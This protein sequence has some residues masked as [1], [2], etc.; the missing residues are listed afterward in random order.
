MNSYLV[1][2]E[3]NKRYGE[4]EPLFDKIK[5]F[6]TQ[7]YQYTGNTW[8]IKSNLSPNDIMTILRPHTYIGDKI[9]VVK[10]VRSASWEGLPIEEEQWLNDF[11]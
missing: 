5:S 6:G 8:V 11:L 4:Y 2:L 10:M 9:L 3:L 7:W 1:G